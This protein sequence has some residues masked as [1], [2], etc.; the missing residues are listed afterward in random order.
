MV[1]S[2][3]RFA[4]TWDSQYPQ[5]SKSWRTHWQNLNTLFLYPEDIR[6]AIY[7][8]RISCCT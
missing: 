7:T 3:D 4:A 6:K 5:I 1:T 8:Q 2:I